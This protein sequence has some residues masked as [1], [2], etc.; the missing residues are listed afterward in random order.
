MRRKR[1]DVRS[2]RRK[3]DVGARAAR[4]VDQPLDQVVRAV[5]AFALEHRFERIEPFLRLERV[6]VVGGGRLRNGG[7]GLVYPD[8][9]EWRGLP[10][11]GGSLNR[12]SPPILDYRPPRSPA[13]SA[14]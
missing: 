6:G 4:L 14:G 5:R 7:H 9:C 13:I 3:R 11:A 1:V 2:V 10:G 8:M 12:K